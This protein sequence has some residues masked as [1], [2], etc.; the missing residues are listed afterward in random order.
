MNVWLHS[1]LTLIP[2]SPL[3]K[4]IET[5]FIMPF[6]AP[7][8][9]NNYIAYALY[10]YKYRLFNSQDEFKGD[11]QNLSSIKRSLR[12]YYKSDDIKLQLLLNR[13]IMLKN[14][15]STIPADRLLFFSCDTFSYPTLKTLL[16]YLNMCPSDIPEVN[17]QDIK[18]DDKLIEL[19]RLLKA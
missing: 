10:N 1:H 2:I 15:F 16:T 19:L 5:N 17:I 11:M 13:I 14:T 7:L 18:Y 8:N 9:I 4:W 6:E 3:E 12:K